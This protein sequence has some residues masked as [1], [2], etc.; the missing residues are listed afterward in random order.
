MIK[1]LL[2]V[3]EKAGVKRERQSFAS[4]DSFMNRFVFIV[5]GELSAILPQSAKGRVARDPPNIPSR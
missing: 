2:A 5:A 1:R 4:T 3:D